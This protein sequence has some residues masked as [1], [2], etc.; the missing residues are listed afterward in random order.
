MTSASRDLADASARDAL[1][2]QRAAGNTLP[3]EFYVDPA[4]HREDVQR[5]FLNHWLV[6]GHIDSIARVGDYFLYDIG[7]ESFIVVR[8]SDEI[9]SVLV[10]VCPHR[11]SRVCL[12]HEGNVKAFVCPYHAW[13][14]DASGA[15]VNPR[16]E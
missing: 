16:P 13:H 3:R 7:F 1:A 11:G 4:V 15:C 9:V 10:N 12:E 14:Y 2:Q 6:A 8:S 5:I